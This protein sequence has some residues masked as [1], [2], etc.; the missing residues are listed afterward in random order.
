M[1]SISSEGILLIYLIFLKKE[2]RLKHEDLT[3]FLRV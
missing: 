3:V 2:N 1:A